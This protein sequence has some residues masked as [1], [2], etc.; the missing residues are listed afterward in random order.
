MNAAVRW[1]ERWPSGASCDHISGI[2]GT[3]Q[4]VSELDFSPLGGEKGRVDVSPLG[5]K[6]TS[7]GHLRPPPLLRSR[8]RSSQALR[9]EPPSLTLLARSSGDVLSA[10]A[11]YSKVGDLFRVARAHRPVK[12]LT[13][14][15]GSVGTCV[16]PGTQMAKVERKAP[17]ATPNGIR[18]SNRGTMAFAPVMNGA[19]GDAVFGSSSI[20]TWTSLAMLPGRMRPR[21]IPKC[22]VAGE[23]A[24]FCV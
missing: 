17:K 14:I 23:R 12:S 19:A 1:A 10:L 13:D 8:Q 24:V 6:G 2:S 20:I 3:F 21:P 4:T 7:S 9:N 22:P 5:P 11:V 15:H 16:L 18:A